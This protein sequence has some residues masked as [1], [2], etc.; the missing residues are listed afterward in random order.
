MAD[1][2]LN[3]LTPLAVFHS[4]FR[5]RQ[6]I[7]QLTK[8]EVVGRYRGSYF[9]LLWSLINPL[10]MLAVYAFFF[11]VVFKAR[12]GEG[13]ASK[14]DFA[15]VLFAGL[16]VFNLFAECVSRAPGLIL[17]NVN[18]VKKVIFPLEILPWV[19]MG[20]A[21]F[22]AA[23]SM[24]VLTAMYAALYQSVP[25][26]IVFLPIVLFPFLLMV[27]GLSWFLASVGVFVRDIGQLIGMVV[28][29][30]LFLSPIFFPITALDAGLRPYLYLSPLTLIVEQVRAV[31][32]WGQVP[33]WRS[34]T[35]YTLVSLVVAWLGLI[36][37]QKTR[38][39]FAD[40]L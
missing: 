12:W 2:P 30:L 34:L 8:R 19:A 13:V 37:F 27:M 36:W 14:T 10:L 3:R 31:L 23:I 9:G 39:G 5:H 20:A 6:L 38:K 15:L 16:I 32:I 11:G 28:T 4:L 18:Y 24:V 33:E 1:K 35:L 26:T 21:L 40:V 7:L 25:W 29:S 17:A 22:H